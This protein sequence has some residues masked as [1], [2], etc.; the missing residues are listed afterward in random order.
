MIPTSI[1]WPNS[2]IWASFQTYYQ[3]QFLT[4]FLNS[5]HIYFLLP[6][7]HYQISSTDSCVDHWRNMPN[8]LPASSPAFSHTTYQR[9]ILKFQS[10]YVTFLLKNLSVISHCL[11]D[12]AQTHSQNIQSLSWSLPHLPSSLIAYHPPTY[13]SFP[14]VTLIICTFP[15]TLSSLWAST[16]FSLKLFLPS[17]YFFQDIVSFQDIF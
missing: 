9:N 12:R 11:Q 5:S 3:T 2:N 13:Q 7:H 14:A 4:K 6:H 8:Y 17:H 1:N 15:R 16:C 10:G